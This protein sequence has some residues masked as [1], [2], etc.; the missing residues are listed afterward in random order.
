M[1]FLLDTCVVSDLARGD[2]NT[3]E[4]LKS[5][6]PMEVK[7]SSLTFYELK[8][9]LAK[10]KQI[11]SSIKRAVYGFLEEVESVEFG[12]NEAILASE[13][14]ATLE[15]RGNPIGAYDILIAA[16]ALAGNHILVTS[17]TREFERI[18]KLQIENWR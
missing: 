11:N 15:S 8:Y 13:I 2:A 4:K 1:A 5:I 3:L 18:E 12:I 10:N 16:T 17:N 14:R 6:P 7:I 9:G